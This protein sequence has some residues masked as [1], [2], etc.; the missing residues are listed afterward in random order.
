MFAVMLMAHASIA[1]EI[2]PRALFEPEPG[3][4]LLI[5]GQDLG[6]IGGFEAPNNSGYVD[7]VGIRPGG[8]TTYLSLP[9]LQGMLKKVN[10]N[11]GDLHAQGIIDNPVFR[12]SVLAIGLHFVGQEKSIAAGKQD[13]QVKALAEWVK[14]A[15]R[16]VFLRIGYEF[17]GSWNKYD[18]EAY[19]QSFQRIVRLFREAGVKNCA[20]V[21]QSCT[22]PVS[23][24]KTRDIRDWYPGDDVVDWMGYSW[25][26][27]AKEQVE[28]TERL[29][30]FA[31]E[32]GKPVM[33]CE[34]APQGYDTGNLTN[35]SIYG[36][37]DSR[38]RTPEEIWKDWYTPW[39]RYVEDNKEIVRVVAYINVN[40][41]SQLMWGPPYRN[42]YWGD[43]RVE[44]NP[45]IKEK[46][47]EKIS[48]ASLLNAS[49]DLFQ[50]L[51]F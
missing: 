13:E 38:P 12:E 45:V 17:D 15:K 43:S 24:Y 7:H 8:V 49:P 22:S 11:S 46:W 19:K 20:M 37:K 3:K 23:G 41:N 33:V 16:P 51:G 35:R 29:L 2:R 42:G 18:P 6:A 5:I 9:A 26:L 14:G 44:V 36:G 48:S 27:N 39:F 34:A 32:K 31:R 28:L 30:A 10:L 50:K 21:W 47:I 4:Q 1:A 25:F 40:W